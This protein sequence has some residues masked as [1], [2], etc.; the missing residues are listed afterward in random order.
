MKILFKKKVDDDNEFVEGLELDIREKH[1]WIQIG[2]SSVEI[3]KEEALK[4]FSLLQ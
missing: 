2:E 4:V 3:T 1:M